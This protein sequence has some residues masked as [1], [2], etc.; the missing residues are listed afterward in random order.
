MQSLPPHTAPPLGQRYTPPYLSHHP[1]EMGPVSENRAERWTA[2]R[3]EVPP[4]QPERAL[5]S[6]N[7]TCG[8]V[9]PHSRNYGLLWPHTPHYYRISAP[10]YYNRG[11]RRSRTYSLPPGSSPRIHPLGPKDWWNNINYTYPTMWELPLRP[12]RQHS[13]LLML[14]LVVFLLWLRCFLLP[15]IFLYMAKTM[16][17]ETTR[18]GLPFRC[19]VS[20][21][22]Y[23]VLQYLHKLLCPC[24]VYSHTRDVLFS[25]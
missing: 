9:G 3:S 14:S 18:G 23:Q 20:F 19:W 10:L 16:A 21:T 11:F 22:V 24:R 7:V 1:L 8:S 17:V 25:V 15:T 5:A 4:S 12:L 2:C 6:N 13:G